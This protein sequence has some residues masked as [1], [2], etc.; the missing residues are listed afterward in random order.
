MTTA[1]SIT[2]E[3]LDKLRRVRGMLSRP[4]ILEQYKLKNIFIQPFD[5]E[6]VGTNS[7]DIRLGEWIFREKFNS[8]LPTFHGQVEPRFLYNMYDPD[9]VKALFEK[10]LAQPASKVLH[11]WFEL[12]DLE[13]I[14]PDDLVIVIRP[15]E[16]ILAHTLEF[17]GSNCNFITTRM[18]ARSTIGRSGL[19]VCRCAGVGDAFYCNRWTLEIT[20]NLQY[21]MIPLVVGRRIGQVIFDGIRP[22]AEN[23]GGY[24][25]E[26]KYQALGSLEKMQSSWKPEDMLPKAYLD[27]ELIG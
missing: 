22:L 8:G 13:G 24:V 9:H 14:S 25:T 11:P 23:D 6:S 27:R 20:N 18:A 21:H 16:S 2:Q 10:E 15:G 17:I 26:G 12:G 1:I 7:Y 4:D 5:L 3:E 19:E